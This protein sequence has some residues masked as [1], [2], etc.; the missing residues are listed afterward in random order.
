M[1]PQGH[2]GTFGSHGM[3]TTKGVTDPTEAPTNE[4]HG[5]TNGLSGIEAP[6]TTFMSL[7]VP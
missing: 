1:V 5:P 7:V 2:P 3:A 6:R 4:L